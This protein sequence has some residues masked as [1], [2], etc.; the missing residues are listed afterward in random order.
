MTR[1]RSTTSGDDRRG[2]ADGVVGARRLADD[3]DAFLEAEERAQS[4]RER[5]ND[6][7]R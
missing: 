2:D 4:L 1:S 5:P 3:L 6:R 7:R